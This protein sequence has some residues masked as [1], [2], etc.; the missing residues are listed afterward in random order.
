MV[1]LALHQVAE[2]T[3][4]RGKAWIERDRSSRRRDGLLVLSGL[5]Q[6]DAQIAMGLGVVRLGREAAAK[7]PDRLAAFPE[8]MLDNAQMMQRDGVTRLGI[9]QSPIGGAGLRQPP[10]LQM[11][12]GGQKQGLAAPRRRFV[13]D[14]PLH[15][16]AGFLSCIAAAV[17]PAK[18][19]A[20]TLVSP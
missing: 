11:L 15:D 13:A 5:H 19:G 4:R 10:R 3:M 16:S 17:M 8:L 7:Q 20:E 12:D 2:I 14:F 9:K 6:H 1:A 18:V